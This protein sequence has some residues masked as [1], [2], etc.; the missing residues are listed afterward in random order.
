MPNFSTDLDEETKH[1][2][3][4]GQ[5]LTELLKQ[6]QYQ[7]LSVAEQTASLLVANE[8]LFDEVPADK[9]KAA[10]EELLAVLHADAKELM[11]TLNKGDKP[12]DE[13]KEKVL[14]LAKKALHPFTLG[15]KEE[16][17]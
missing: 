10:Q 13:L 2:I 12:T 11:A 1:R 8:G 9:V 16:K 7:P 14:K 4:R 5:R 6:K 3:E 17:K 15:K